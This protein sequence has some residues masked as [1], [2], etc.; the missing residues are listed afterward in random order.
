MIILAN[1]LVMDAFLKYQIFKSCGVFFVQKR[2]PRSKIFQI[3]LKIP[4]M[5]LPIS[6]LIWL[7]VLSVIRFVA[8]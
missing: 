3:R 8:R 7:H 5:N 4:G 2:L 6:Y 1:A